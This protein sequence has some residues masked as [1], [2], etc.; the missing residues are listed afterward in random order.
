LQ[1][2]VLA[3]SGNGQALDGLWLAQGAFGTGQAIAFLALVRSDAKKFATIA[4]LAPH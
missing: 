3:I 1:Q 2:D 4:F